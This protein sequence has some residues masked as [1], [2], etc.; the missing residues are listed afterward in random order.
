M[1]IEGKRPEGPDA[2]W[3]HLPDPIADALKGLSARIADVERRLPP[4]AGDNVPGDVVPLR[5]RRGPNP[6]GG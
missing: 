6:A 4:E 2:D 3:I 5:P 1:R